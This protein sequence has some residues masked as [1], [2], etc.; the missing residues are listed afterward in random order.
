MNA[1]KRPDACLRLLLPQSLEEQV[2]D[3]LLKHAGPV[4]SFTATTVDGHGAPGSIASAAEQVRGRAARVQIEIP[5]AAADADELVA[6][7]RA[8]MPNADIAWWLMPV[9]ASGDFR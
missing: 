5:I 8:E 2:I 7:L 6:H 3:L 1:A 4:G 9:L